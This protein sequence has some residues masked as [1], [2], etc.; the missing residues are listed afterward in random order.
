MPAPTYSSAVARRVAAAQMSARRLSG[1]AL[2]GASS[3]IF[4]NR[5]CAEQSRSPRWIT[6][7]WVSASTCTSTW[8]ALPIQRS[9]NRVPSPNAASASR[10]AEVKASRRPAGLSTRTMPRPPPPAD[11][12]SSTG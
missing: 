1:S 4:W 10:E 8:R 9:T 3:T 7:P 5:R 2:A 6:E 12:L 11:A